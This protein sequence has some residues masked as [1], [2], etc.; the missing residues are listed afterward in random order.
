MQ[1]KRFSI[2]LDDELAKRMYD[3]KWIS[4]KSVNTLIIE[5]IH[6]QIDKFEEH[7]KWVDQLRHTAE[8]HEDH[9]ALGQTIPGKVLVRLKYKPPKTTP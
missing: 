3:L 2:C 9:L 6:N 1:Y 4:R 5:M 8:M 7:Y